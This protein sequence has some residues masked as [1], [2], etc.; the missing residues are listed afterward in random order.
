[1]AD[2]LTFVFESEFEDPTTTSGGGWLQTVVP[3]IWGQQA[4]TI[5]AS[6]KAPFGSVPSLSV[7]VAN[8]S[9]IHP[10]TADHRRM[11]EASG[12]PIKAR[13]WHEPCASICMHL[14]VVNIDQQSPVQFSVQVSGLP[15]QQPGGANATRLFTA[16]YNATLSST[17][18][19]SDW[20]GAGESNVYEV[21]CDQ[22][23]THGW[24]ACVSRRVACK[25]GFTSA[26]GAIKA[27]P[28]NA[29]CEPM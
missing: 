12:G 14:I 5:Q 4:R 23:K 3:A 2:Q 26:R 13:A 18:V 7:S 19:L 10:G 28:H 25:H 9:A 8:A 16:S 11:I 6:F 20:I 24:E 29:T 17:G 27:T 22:L 1:M 15:A 21:G